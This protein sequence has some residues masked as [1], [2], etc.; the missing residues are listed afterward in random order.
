M[1]LLDILNESAEQQNIIN[2]IKVEFSRRFDRY[3]AQYTPQLKQA[4]KVIDVFPI[5]AQIKIH[6]LNR[7]T[8][9]YPNIISGKGGDK[10]GYNVKTS[11]NGNLGGRICTVAVA[12]WLCDPDNQLKI[13]HVHYQNNKGHLIITDVREYFIEEIEY[14]ILNQGKGFL[15]MKTDNKNKVIRAREKLDRELWLQEFQC[16]YVKFVEDTKKR[17]DTYAKEFASLTV[18]SET[19]LLNFM[20]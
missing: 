20:S 9:E 13:V 14:T 15:F 4:S 3:V 5:V 7:I 19:N 16:K 17:F 12:K 11:E 6:V 1:K 18:S 2:K 10:F 8:Q